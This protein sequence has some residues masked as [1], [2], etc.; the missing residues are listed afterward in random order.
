LADLPGFPDLVYTNTV[1][2]E[3]VGVEGGYE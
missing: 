3:E 1:Y 2:V